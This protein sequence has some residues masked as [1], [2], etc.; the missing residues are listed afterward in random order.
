MKKLTGIIL[1]SL[2]AFGMTACGS[3]D[4][5]ERQTGFEPKLDKATACKI[6]IAGTYSN[7]EALEAEF[8]RFNEYYPNVEMSYTKIDDYNNSIAT[9]LNGNDAPNIFFSF[10]W[11]TGNSAYDS[12]F[13]HMENLA[14]DSLG[15]DLD[16]IRQGLLNRDSQ[17][18][19]LTVPI[20]STSYGMLVNNDLFE[21]EGLKVPG[22]LQELFDVCA[23]FR[24]KGYASPMMGYSADSSGC[25]M[26]TVAYP[27]FAGTLAEHPEMVARANQC[28]PAAGEYMRPALETLS[29]MIGMGCI[30]L[31]KCNGIGDNYA[32]VIMRF[33]EGDVPMMICTGDTVS[34]T[35][36]R[37]SQSE[38]FTAHPFS[39]TFAPIPT[40][41]KGGYFLD[42]PSVQFSVNN[43]CSDKDMT[44]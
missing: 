29:Q 44:N 39:Y 17:D 32:E 22:T 10:S 16:C 34:G 13:A 27:I 19:V 28:D 5:Q 14:D 42:S 33:F 21:K 8:D 41:D 11:M 1:S 35:G 43:S 30:D 31:E 36:K 6:S 25:L 40:T 38:A 37:E 7:F 9:V 18:R 23:S 3:E 20:F 26:N 12:V 2:I 24:E 4:S 15:L